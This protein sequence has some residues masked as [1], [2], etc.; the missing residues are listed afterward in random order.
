MAHSNYYNALF[1]KGDSL[2]SDVSDLL[3]TPNQEM[4]EIN[5]NQFNTGDQIKVASQ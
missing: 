3:A 2:I 1:K 4:E 5:H